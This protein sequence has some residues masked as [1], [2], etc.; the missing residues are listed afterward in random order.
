MFHTRRYPFLVWLTAITCLVSLALAGC[1]SAPTPVPTPTSVPTSVPFPYG[2][3]V[4]EGPGYVYVF[5]TDGT[6]KFDSGDPG[7]ADKGTYSVQGNQITF[8]TGDYCDAQKAGKGVY[9]WALEGD[10]VTFKAVGEDPCPIRT[11]TTTIFPWHVKK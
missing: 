9:T 1:G 4:S 8:L 11:S 10:K 6:F 7:E 2:T 3:L 5:N